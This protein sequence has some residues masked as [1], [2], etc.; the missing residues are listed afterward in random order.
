[1]D[2][3]KDWH[4]L[5]NHDSMSVADIFISS[6]QPADRTDERNNSLG[7]SVI[8]LDLNG[9]DIESF[10]VDIDIYRSGSDITNCFGRSDESKWRRITS[11]PD[12]FRRQ[13]VPDVA[14]PF[15]M[16]RQPLV[17]PR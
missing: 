13:P 15:L 17:L 8:R 9:I 3:P 11:S 14:H 12:R 16:P 2:A 7:Q 6:C 10:R 1:M 4:N 5:N